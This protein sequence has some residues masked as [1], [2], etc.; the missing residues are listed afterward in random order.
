MNVHMDDN[1]NFHYATPFA[2]AYAYARWRH[3]SRESLRVPHRL[4]PCRA[5]KLNTFLGAVL[6]ARGSPEPYILHLHG[7]GGTWDGAEDTNAT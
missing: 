5:A 1:G 3:N 4:L 2:V 7:V 6:H